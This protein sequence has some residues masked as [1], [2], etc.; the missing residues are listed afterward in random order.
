MIVTAFILPQRQPVKK[1]VEHYFQ[2]FEYLAKTNLPI[3]LFL[4]KS[5]TK[6][7]PY[8]NVKV[9][10]IEIRDLRYYKYIE[11]KDQ[12]PL[13]FHMEPLNNLDYHIIINSKT[14]LVRLATEMYGGDRF[15]W[16]DFGISHFIGSDQN[17]WSKLNMLKFLKPGLTLP[18]WYEHPTRYSN[19]L[20][21]R[22]LGSIFSGSRRDIIEFDNVQKRAYEDLFPIIDLEVKMWAHAEAEY[23]WNPNWYK[24]NF[25]DTIFNF[26]HLVDY[27]NAFI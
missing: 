23:G 2:M 15:T 27:S 8:K 9:H 1:S 20:N 7:V 26:D 14:E 5:I 4:D 25:G 24:G 12:I 19:D 16:V 11:A 17:V 13:S 21:W 6:E 10:K 3:S 22:F 18:G